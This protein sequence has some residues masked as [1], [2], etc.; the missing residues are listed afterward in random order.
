[1]SID[2]G[3]DKEGVVYIHTMEYYSAIRKNDIL[4]F[5]A[6]WMNLEIIILSEVKQR[7][8]N[9]IWHT[10]MWNLKNNTNELIYETETDSDIE[11]KF[12]VIKGEGG[13]GKIRSMG[14]TDTNYY[15]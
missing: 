1:M 11:N 13:M 12:M 15:I 6:T 9:I 8:T 4:P 14:L 2:G 3:M 7:N 5:A 10:H